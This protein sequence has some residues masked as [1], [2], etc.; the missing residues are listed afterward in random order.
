[1]VGVTTAEEFKILE[2]VQVCATDPGL[3]PQTLH[4][5]AKTYFCRIFLLEFDAD[6]CHTGRYCDDDAADDLIDYLSTILVQEGQSAF[7]FLLQDA[8]RHYPYCREKLDRIS[9]Q[10]LYQSSTKIHEFAV[11]PGYICNLLQY[12]TRIVLFCCVFFDQKNESVDPD[13]AKSVFKRLS[14][15]ISLSLELGCRMDQAGKSNAALQLMLQSHSRSAF[16]IDANLDIH[17][18]TPAC[19]EL[20]SD[21]DVFTIRNKR[22]VAMRKDVESALHAVANQMADTGKKRGSCAGSD[23]AEQSLLLTRPNNRLARVLVRGLYAEIEQDR[24]GLEPYVLVEVREQMQ[25][26]QDI[27]HILKSCFDLSEKESQLAYFLTK[28]GSLTIALEALGITRN[29]AKTHLRRIY[30]KTATQSQ[31]ELSKLLHGL[32]GLL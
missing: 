26:P 27:D 19:E 13:L 7:A 24:S 6:G 17:V 20:L 4:H 25:L 1:M 8:L 18:S 16:L 15:T 28:T 12:D 11:F 14:K 5:I 23:L 32:S 30:E 31:L 10:S 9:P 3:W 22:L 21:G 29:T 2:N